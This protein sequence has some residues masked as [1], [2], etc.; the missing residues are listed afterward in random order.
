[1]FYVE[2]VEQP[3]GDRGRRPLLRRRSAR[4]TGCQGRREWHGR[5]VRQASLSELFQVSIRDGCPFHRAAS[6]VAQFSECDIRKRTK[7]DFQ[8]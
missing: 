3:G 8:T 4:K 5:K 1:M 2:S 6:N 7:K